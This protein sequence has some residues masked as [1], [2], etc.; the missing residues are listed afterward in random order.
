MLMKR[1]RGIV[2]AVTAIA[3]V[4]M[5]ALAGLALASSKTLNAVNNTTLN[6]KI[7]VDSS[8]RTVYALK[9]ETTKKL[10]CTSKSCLKLWPMATVKKGTK[11]TKAAGIKGKLTTVKRGG[12][13]QLV[14][15][16]DPL[17]YYSQDKRKGDVNGNGIKSFGGT[18]HVIQANG[19]IYGGY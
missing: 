2:A 19:V 1:S 7:A 13:Y 18:W 4:A 9:G 5:L 11:L 3:A 14:L 8:G 16:G 6:K 15:G 10:L 12:A 17:Y